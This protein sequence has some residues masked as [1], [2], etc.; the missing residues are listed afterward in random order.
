MNTDTPQIRPLA[1]IAGVACVVT[2]LT[3]LLGPSLFN[4]AEWT[5]YH[6]ITVSV[7]FVTMT[8]LHLRGDAWRNGSKM[9]AIGFVALAVV[10]TGLIV[11]M[12]VGRQAE[13]T[14]AT[15][16]SAADLNGR[17]AR[18]GADLEAAKQRLATAQRM[19]DKEM[20]GQ[21]CGPRCNAWKENA[22]DITNAVKQIEGELAALGP[23][24]PVNADAEKI[25]DLAEVFNIDRGQAIAFWTLVKP[26]ALTLLFE[27]GSV[28]S[29]AYAFPHKTAPKARETVAEAA[30]EQAPEAV[31][32][33]KKAAALATNDNLSDEALT[34]VAAL[35]RGD[36]ETDGTDGDGGGNVVPIKRKASKAEV[37]AALESH[38]VEN[39]SFPS[40]ASIARKYGVAPA[41]LHGWFQQWEAEG[42]SIRR[43]QEGRRK[44][45]G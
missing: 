34:T 39:G 25:A 32:A 44:V 18:K 26:F 4:P 5:Q 41:T 24:K 36:I 27:F 31:F 6:F 12:S 11:G 29:F 23:Q 2:A 13:A 21:R 42:Q 17:I 20:T 19:A 9:V 1:I 37:R 7:V 38:V 28:I 16:M 8:F 30:V 40:Q 14:G 22:I 3:I 45:V 15:M 10:G 35:F 43:R 33:T